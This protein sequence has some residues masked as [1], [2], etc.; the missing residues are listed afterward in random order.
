MEFLLGARP[1][2]LSGGCGSEGL[3]GGFSLK[4]LRSKQPV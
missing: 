3:Q 2:A 1:G 4:H